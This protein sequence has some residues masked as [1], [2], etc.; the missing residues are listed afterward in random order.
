[1]S[2]HHIEPPERLA[3]LPGNLATAILTDGVCTGQDGL[4]QVAILRASTPIEGDSVRWSVDPVRELVEEAMNRF[5]ATR[6]DADAWLAPRLHA[7]L[8]MTRAEAANPGLWNFLALAVAPDFVLWRHMPSGGPNG[9]VPRKVN[10]ARFVGPHYS[11]AFARL[12]WAA[13]MF[14]DG[15]DYTPAEIA[16][17]NQDMINTALRLAAIDHKPTALALVRVLKGLSDGGATRL[18]DR[19]N[20][21]CTAVN[22]AGSTLMYEVIGPDEAPDQAALTDWIEDAESA[23]AVPW[24]RLPQGPDDG[25]VLRSS[26]EVLSRMFEQ[27][28]AEAPLRDRAR[29]GV[30]HD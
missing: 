12:W 14:R 2:R 18:G 6:T 27:F 26:C 23:P 9:G 21:L 10:S 4:P 17:G 25:T 24:D 13:E 15:P 16:C 29:S 7:T 1:M 8:R 30:A 5:D 28:A 22:A 20:A 3:L 11:Q 19:V